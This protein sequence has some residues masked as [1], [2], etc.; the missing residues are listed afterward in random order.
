MEARMK[1]RTSVLGRWPSIR[2]AVE[3]LTVMGY[4][5]MVKDAPNEYGEY[6]PDSC[7]WEN[8]GERGPHF[9]RVE[10]TPGE[11]AIVRYVKKLPERFMGVRV[12][13]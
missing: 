13:A 5:R 1:K 7:T 9:V 12:A 8:T 3:V 10:V 4:R 2:S 11:C 6:A